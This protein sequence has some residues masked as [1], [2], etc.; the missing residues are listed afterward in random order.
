MT[1]VIEFDNENILSAYYTFLSIKNIR[2]SYE[3]FITNLNIHGHAYISTI[4]QNNEEIPYNLKLINFFSFSKLDFL[5]D[6][7]EVRQ[8]KIHNLGVFAK[9]SILKNSIITLYPVNFFYFRGKHEKGGLLLSTY[10]IKPNFIP[11]EYSIMLNE[12]IIVCGDP[13]IKNNNNYLG[14]II[15]DGFK[16]IDNNEE[17]YT[18]ISNK[19]KNAIIAPMKSDL[20]IFLTVVASRDIEKDE[21]IFTSYGIEY[22]RN[23]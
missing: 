16:L 18:T 5:M 2:E 6:N 7:V 21:E 12:N 17:I 4:M 23:V 20:P 10:D 8:S 14:H 19:R 13:N 11:F 1:D 3:E 15:N 9:K 22:W